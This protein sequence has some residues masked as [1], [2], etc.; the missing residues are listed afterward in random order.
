MKA[1]LSEHLL[2]KPGVFTATIARALNRMIITLKL[3]E[4]VPNAKNSPEVLHQRVQYAEWFLQHGV[5]AHLVFI[6]KTGYNV[7]TRRSQG[8]EPRRFA[9]RRVVDIQRRRNCNVTFAISS[10]VGLVHHRIAFETVADTVQECAAGFPDDEPLYLIYDRAS[11]HSRHILHSRLQL[12]A[13]WGYWSG[14][15]ESETDR[16]PSKQE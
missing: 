3:V 8:R 7:W 4:D 15:N 6:D 1:S 16:L 10:K 14:N 12:N 9:A 2:E 13:P 11:P 5:L